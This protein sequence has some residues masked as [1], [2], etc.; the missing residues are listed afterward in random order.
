MLSIAIPVFRASEYLPGC[1]DGFLPLRSF[2]EI[3]GY[4]PKREERRKT[5]QSIAGN[6]GELES[7]GF[8]VVRTETGVY[9][10]G[11]NIHQV[12]N[13]S[14]AMKE[15]FNEKNA[16]ERRYFGIKNGVENSYEN[17][18]LSDKPQK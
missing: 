7:L 14:D 10:L 15:L 1:L 17:H 3:S 9:V 8:D 16:N 13:F 12:A 4:L 18:G 6:L 5:T 11:I 2:T